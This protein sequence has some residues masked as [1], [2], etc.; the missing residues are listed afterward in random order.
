MTSASTE[1]IM[2]VFML[3]SAGWDIII[4][5]YR[6]GV[7]LGWTNNSV[8]L[9]YRRLRRKCVALFGVSLACQSC[10]SGVYLANGIVSNYA[11]IL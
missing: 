1:S 10:P 3:F 2:C 8:A 5:L 7:Q 6:V 9:D 4:V 11:N